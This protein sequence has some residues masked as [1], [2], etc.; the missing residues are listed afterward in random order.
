MKNALILLIF[1]SYFIS[2]AQVEPMQWQSQLP[3]SYDYN[4]MEVLTSNTIVAVG[5]TGSFIRSDDAG[6]A[7]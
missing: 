7:E 2:N 4:D 3:T 5:L 6:A 1:L